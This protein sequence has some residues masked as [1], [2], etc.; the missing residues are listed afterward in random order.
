MIF[1]E[2]KRQALVAEATFLEVIECQLLG[3]T[4]RKGITLQKEIKV[5][6]VLKRSSFPFEIMILGE[7]VVLSFAQCKVSLDTLSIKY[8]C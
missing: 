1:L 2:S 4:W 7:E 6:V 3:V 5:E 8:P